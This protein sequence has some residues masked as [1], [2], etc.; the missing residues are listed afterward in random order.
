MNTRYA[1]D[2][3]RYRT[4]TTEELRR[5]FLIENLFRA[6]ELALTYFETER[7]VVGSAVPTASE[8]IL[9]AGRELAAEYFCQ[10]REL[11]VL[12]IGGRG[13][14]SVDG[15]VHTL[16]RLD[17]LYV[18]RGTRRVTFASENP[19]RP[20]KL[21]LLSYPAHNEYPTAVV[22]AGETEPV[23]LGS[24]R[25]A[26][27]R[28][29]HKC[30]HAGGIQSCQLVMGYTALEEGSVWNTMAPHT[31]ARRTEVY[32][33]FDLDDGMLVHL[34]GEPDQTRHLVVRDGEAVMSPMWSIH[35]GVA[36]HAYTF[37]WGMGG[38]NQE[39]TDMDDVSIGDLR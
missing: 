31:H 16:E 1:T 17:C 5:S 25:E 14:V 30:I 7:A 33:Y 2:R 23:E 24:A 36:T 6:G 35:S 26:N 37:C 8:L 38:E 13:M 21:Y 4:M 34:L 10:R 20:A 11:G 15:E 32:M 39:F 28:T 29:I 22:R 9:E 18:G 19:E 3:V 12:N 27:R